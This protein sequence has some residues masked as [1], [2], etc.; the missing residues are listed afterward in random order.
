MRIAVPTS[1]GE[2][3][4]HFGKS[5]AFALAD[6]DAGEATLSRLQTVEAPGHEQGRLPEW[7]KQNEVD[8]VIA[9]SLGGRAQA[10]LAAL[11]IEVIMGAPQQAPDFLV[12]AFL[13]GNLECQSQPC[14]CG[15]GEHSHSD[16]HDGAADGECHG[17]CGCH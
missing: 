15:H 3:S 7:L 4:A 10:R 8:V 6:C 11:Q 14:S 13:Q 16:G 1:N 5:R 2:L 17:G 9:G 12:R